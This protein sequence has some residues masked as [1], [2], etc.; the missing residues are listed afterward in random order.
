MTGHK[1]LAI[2]IQC[3][4]SST[5]LP[6]KALKNLGG[7]TVFEWTLASMKKV[8][9]DSYMVATDEDSYDALAPLAEKNGWE[10]MKGP[11]EDVLERY[12]MA[13]RKTGCKAV[14]RATADNPFLFYEAAESLVQEFY[15]QEKI[16]HCDYMTW[17]GL[18][19]GS[20][21]EIFWA[22]SL[23]KASAETSDHFDREHVGPA[24]YNHKDRFTSLF[25]KAP[26]RFY[27]PDYRTTIDTSADYR[28]ALAVVNRLSGGIAPN[29]PYTTEQI[30][31]AIKEPEVHDTILFYPST[32]KGQGTGHL[33]RALYCALE[34][35]GFVYIPENP[36]LSETES[37][38]KEFESKGLKDYQIVRKFPENNEY[39][40]I[41]SDAFKLEPDIAAKLSGRA[42][43][44]AIDEGGEN[45]EYCDYL[46]DILPSFKIDRK[47]NIQEP[48]Y[49]ERP[50][51]I[52]SER[53]ETF[54]KILISLGGED[55][56]SLAVPAA[57]YFSAVTGGNSSITVILQEG[58]AEAEKIPGVNVIPPVQNLKEYLFEYDLVVT[59]YGFTA[60]E[61]LSANCAVVLLSTTKLHE[62]L[63][64]KY[65]FLCLSRKDLETPESSKIF[66]ETAAFFPDFD[67]TGK[68]KNLV[69]KIKLLSHGRRYPCPV[70]G[71]HSFQNEIIARTS[72][73]TFRRCSKCSMIY[74]SWNNSLP[75]K[76]EKE[77]FA[78]QYKKQYGKT[79]LED[80]DHIKKEGF[81]RIGEINAALRTKSISSP[82]L[83]DIGCAY[84]PFLAAASER[85]WLPYGTDIAMDG[86]DFI[87]SKLLYPAVVSSF[88]EFDPAREF[89]INQFDAVTMWYVIEHF[90]NL[91]DVLAKVSSLVKTGGIFAFSTPSA[92][93]VSGRKNREGFF[94]NSPSDHFTVWEP[95]KVGKILKPF[96]FEVVKIVS[97]GHHPERFP[98]VREK[99]ISKDD[100]I[101]KYY[102]TLS[103]M[104][105][106][107]DTFEVYCRK[108]EK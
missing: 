36:E 104:L 86:V 107:G 33:R 20:G 49:I 46:F 44:C 64:K 7:K 103:R 54:N 10:I 59:H 51:N 69:E 27:N 89:G 29:E 79:Y 62:N 74:I 100:L 38:L 95:S 67:F 22:S 87:R 99:N 61:A 65:G 92:E 14:L 45:T 71:E 106:M 105:K 76:Y 3:R 47:A 48:S 23:L 40:L 101:F 88:P 75:M 8:K 2:I 21:V 98:K 57:K 68:K 18:P 4:L 97:T 13:I 37:L 28:R 108:T 102:G 85:G 39:A 1:E 42:A 94:E 32:K 53:P 9:A 50:E 35:G 77:Y 93:G 34:S 5:R 25:Y 60:F 96:G 90:S 91:R 11:L 43:L 24:L 26:S 81:K 15:K 83:L 52:K 55:P 19:H 31:S 58:K 17:T 16:A 56:A 66:R 82:K 63:A 78:E 41:V 70:C 73:R 30:L 80:F 6:G 72:E 84:G 12:C